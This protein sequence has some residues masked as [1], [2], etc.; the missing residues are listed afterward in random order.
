MRK[1]LVNFGVW[2]AVMAITATMVCAQVELPEPVYQ[3]SMSASYEPENHQ[4]EGVKRIRWRN[5]SSVPIDEL[6]FHLYLNAFANDR[7][8]FMVGSGGKLRG[9]KIP[10]DGWGWIEVETMR[11]AF[12]ADLVA[13]GIVA[14]EEGGEPFRRPFAPAV[15]GEPEPI[16]LD[17]RPDLKEVEEFIRPDDGNEL[18][19]T[20]VRYPL[21]K[22][23]QP[24]EWV[25]LEIEFTAQM[26]QIFARTGMHGDFVLGGQWFPKIGVFEDVG[27]R[28]RAEPGWNTHQFHA[29]SEF[30]ADFGDWDVR[31]KLPAEYAGR[32][33]ATGRLVEESVEGDTVTAHFIQPGVHDFAWTASPDFIVVED[34]FDPDTDVPPEQTERM[35]ALLGV[36]REEL[37]L[38]AVDIKLLLQPAHRAQ[39]DRYIEAAKAAIRG[40][41]LPLGAYPY[42]TLTMVDP[43]RG[44]MGAGG[45]EYPTFITLGTHPVLNLPGFD[46]VLAAE[47]VTVHEFGHN[48]FQG[49]IASNEFE[50]AWIDEGMNSFYEMVVMDGYYGHMID[51]FGLRST[52]F[53]LS[54]LQLGDGR[55][56]DSI[57]QPAW[58]YRS[59]GSYG[60]NSYSRPAV[61]LRHLENILGEETFARAMRR[62]FQTWRFRHPSTEDFKEIML[63]EAGADLTWFL[64]QAFHTDRRLDYRIRTARSRPDKDPRGWFWD[65]DGQKTLLGVADRHESDAEDDAED[66][67]NDDS[68]DEEEFYRTEVVVER[69]GEFIHPVTIEFVFEDGE[70][71]RYE[72]DGRSRWKKYVEV[73][74]AK[75]VSAEVDPDHLL[76]LDVDPLNNS[77]RLKKNR[78]PAAKMITHL[79]F[80]LQNLFQLTSMVG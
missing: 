36:P 20:V 75:L 51:L 31:L 44:G 16:T 56:S 77:I 70:S 54:R 47:S 68:D 79:V 62:F 22:P 13:E 7:S 25:E 59:G 4:V 71:V 53:D 65:D 43:P 15:P 61:T 58:T 80:W 69:R 45:M 12:G 74:Q 78:K 17:D 2:A 10:E 11:L 46:K 23:I 33:G 1:P 29:N 3:V 21:P 39:A 76:A 42:Q 63:D 18:D 64:E 37:R 14:E 72:W 27:D 73:R 57:V 66:D 49:M 55:Y 32:I 50:E 52:S 38:Q 40:Y 19:R 60:L 28:G 8:T 34:R 6:Q 67:D 24:G 41:G 30:F 9:V 35:A 5:T 26:P 48:F